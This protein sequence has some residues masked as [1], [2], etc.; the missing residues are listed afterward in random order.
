MSETATATVLAEAYFW[1]RW[2][3]TARPWKPY[4]RRLIGWAEPIS[5][6][7]D[8]PR[9]RRRGRYSTRRRDD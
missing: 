9:C 8:G 7:K 3:A 6:R 4:S 2:D 5:C 1:N